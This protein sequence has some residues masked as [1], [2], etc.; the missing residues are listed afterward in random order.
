MKQKNMSQALKRITL[1]M[2][3]AVLVFVGCATK[4]QSPDL[5]GL[6]NELIQAEDPYRNPVIVVPGILG[7]KLKDL[8]SNAVVWGAF[9]PGSANP[10]K[11]ETARLIALPMREG[12]PLGALHDNVRPDGVL[13]QIEVHFAG[14]D[15]R[16]KAYFYMLGTLGAGYRDS[17]L[18]ESGAIDYGDSHYT[19]FQFA[20][21][22]RRDIVESARM[23]HEFI[24]SQRAYVQAETEK[25]YGIKDLDVKFDIVA[26]SMGGLVVRYY[27]RYGPADLPSDGSLPPLT[28]A[29]ARY[30][31]NVVMVG[32]P[33]AG[34]VD[35]VNDLVEG[36][37]FAPFFGTYDSA[38]LG[39]MPSIYQLLPRGRHGAVINA[40]T[41]ERI[42]DIYDPALWERMNWGLADPR[43]DSVLQMLLPEVQDVAMR[44]RIAL[45]HQS[46]ALRRAKQFAAA[47]DLRAS[48]PAGLSLYLIA[49]DAVP[50]NA[51]VAVD[52]YSGATNVVKEAPG[53]GTV[54]RS[55][56]LMDEGIGSDVVGRLDSPID[57]TSVHFL[58]TDHIGLTKDPGFSDNLLYLLFE[59]PK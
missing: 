2:A 38:I 41:E 19:C 25:R 59:K 34:S 26:H 8:D 45:D 56:A 49:G 28:W 33:N 5:G 24:L 3:A 29:G 14:L 17:E 37:K 30:I 18:G 48:P 51:V 22:W 47:L 31:E 44:R 9:G 52:T 32:T 13:D 16:L 1:V 40:S 23:L 6:Y 39:T 15:L 55:S 27:L 12:A 53:D 4:L 43:Q 21:D 11:P 57:W 42:A 58:F 20:Y 46:K 54:L 10:K 50:T 35:S 7:S 36:R